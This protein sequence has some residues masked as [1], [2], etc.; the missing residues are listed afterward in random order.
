MRGKEPNE[1]IDKR[2]PCVLLKICE[3]RSNLTEVGL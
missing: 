1:F 2:V 3:D